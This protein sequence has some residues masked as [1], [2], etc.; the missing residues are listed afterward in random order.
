MVIDLA[1]EK[2]IDEDY[3]NDLETAKKIFD[4]EHQLLLP[5]ALS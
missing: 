1:E 4:E 3:K 5:I 2:E